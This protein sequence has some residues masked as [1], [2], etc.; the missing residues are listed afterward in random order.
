MTEPNSE[1]SKELSEEE[2]KGAS[3]GYNAGTNW[4]KKKT[5]FSELSNISR[6]SKPKNKAKDWDCPEWCE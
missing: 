3:G 1:T 6:S 2:L 5:S 4:L